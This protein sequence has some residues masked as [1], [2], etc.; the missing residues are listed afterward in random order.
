MEEGKGERKEIEKRRNK[1][2]N[3]E[4]SFPTSSKQLGWYQRRSGFMMFMLPEVQN[5]VDVESKAGRLALPH[6]TQSSP[7]VSLQPVSPQCISP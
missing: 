2:E 7:R 4:M 1:R 5:L 3:R 6:Q